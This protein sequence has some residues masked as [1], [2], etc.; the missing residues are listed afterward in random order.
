MPP[1][2]QSH[3]TW[4]QSATL[5]TKLNPPLEVKLPRLITSSRYH[6][7]N[8]DDNQEMC[9]WSVGS[10]V[11]EIS[12][13]FA[14]LCWFQGTAGGLRYPRSSSWKE[15]TSSAPRSATLPN[16]MS[17]SNDAILGCCQCNSQSGLTGIPQKSFDEANNAW[18]RFAE[19]LVFLELPQESHLTRTLWRTSSS[20][21]A[22]AEGG[23]LPKDVFPKMLVLNKVQHSC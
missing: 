12:A 3:Y 22:A 17:Y 11:T 6:A 7:A 20:W 15:W 13:E 19:S 16:R 23:T 8:F 18:Q 1:P 9:R 5:F 4:K 2:E 14:V 21:S 10:S